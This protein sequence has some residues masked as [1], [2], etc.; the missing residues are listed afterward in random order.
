MA[1]V[2]TNKGLALLAKLTQGKTL[3]ITS[4]KTGAGT[5][6]ASLLL[7]QT[8][9]TNPKQT[10]TIK[11]NS[12]TGDGKCALVLSV[13]NDDVTTGYSIMQ[14]G[15][16]A[17]DPDEG[18]VLF[19]LWQI[20]SGAGINIPSN[21]VLPGYNA[22]MNYT[23]I[24]D[25]ADSV[26][27]NV[28]PSNTVSQAAME[29]YVTEKVGTTKEDVAKHT[30]NKQNPH[31]VTA[32]QLGLAKVATSGSYND[33]SNKPAIPS[34]LPANGGN[35]DTVDGKHADDFA[36][37][38]H[39]HKYAGSSTAGGSATSAE[40]LAAAKTIQVDLGSESAPG[41]DG[42]ANVSP[43]VKGTLPIKH[44]GTDA[45]TLEA[46][47][48]NLGII[49]IEALPNLHIWA[50]Y[51][52]NPNQYT[53]VPKNNI[54]IAVRGS[55]GVYSNIIYATSINVSDGV[56]TLVT[57]RVL[58]GI[59]GTTTE[60]NKVIEQISGNFVQDMDGN[61][62]AVSSVTSANISNMVSGDKTC[63]QITMG[64]SLVTAHQRICFV[65]STN[66]TAYPADGKHTDDYW[67]KYRKQLAED[68][69]PAFTYGTEDLEPGVSPLATGKLYIVYE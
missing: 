32:A 44:G 22:E 67:Y 3:E 9:V 65:A 37:A 24:Y 36:P 19:S 5:V 20:D 48:E 23:I 54:I 45:T 13:T 56:I 12:Y 4:A 14:I 6:D 16:Y 11:G 40:K 1:T 59:T 2:I 8:G 53:V 49:T 26:N 64:L 62:Y 29:A 68:P 58:S 63:L 38:T 30:A 15:I 60:H 27:V 51:E 28:D 31:G 69:E 7:Q 39:D 55:D 10:M 18:E 61:V 50:K 33:L 43:G 41:F 21:T 47:Q 17:N 25:Q 52:D 34:V 42:S 35:A 46:A 66:E 57:P